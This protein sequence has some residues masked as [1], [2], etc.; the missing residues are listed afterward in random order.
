MYIIAIGTKAQLIKMAPVLRSF[1]EKNVPYEFILTG[2]HKETMFDI[3]LDFELR[4]PV[5]V[6]YED[7]ES[8]TSLRLIKWFLVSFIRFVK[9]LKKKQNIKGIVVHGDTMSTLWGTLVGRLLNIPVIHVEAG[10]RS[11][12]LVRPFPEELVRIMVTKFATVLFPSSEWA[13]GNLVR[14]KNKRII[15]TQEN[16]LLDSLRYAYENFDKV[17][18]VE[19]TYILVSIHRVENIVNKEVFT[20]IVNQLVENAKYG[21]IKFVLHP[22]TKNAIVKWGLQSTLHSSGIE[23]IDR[24]SYI[25]FMQLLNGSRGLVTDGGSN[26]EECSYMGLPCLLM[27]KETE[28]KEGIGDNVTLSN[29]DPTIITE[30]VQECF[31]EQ[32]SPKKLPHHSPSAVIA[33]TLLE[34]S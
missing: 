3:I 21:H 27:R 22:V 13:R 1:D 19:E 2:Q 9:Y 32:W 14:Y 33:E 11:F 4:Q 16:T 18:M 24:M 10:L 31:T 8:D 30:F 7:K 20:F 17:K 5:Q 29:L 6:L 28:R 15:N 26:Q 25:P 23:L 12:N 34:L